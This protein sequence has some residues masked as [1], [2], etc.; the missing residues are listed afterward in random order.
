M[1]FLHAHRRRVPT[2]DVDRRIVIGVRFVATFDAGEA[3]LAFA[4]LGIYAAAHRTGLRRV[5]RID[6]YERP[7]A[8][9]ELVCEDCLKRS[10]S[11]V[12]NAPVQSALLANVAARFLRRAS[13]GGGHVFD[14]QVF[15]N[16]DSEAIGDAE[17]RLVLPVPANAGA[18]GREPRCAT[19]RGEPPLRA[20][21][22][23]R[24][25]ALCGT[26]ATLDGFEG[27]RDRQMLPGGERQRI[28]DAAI[29]PDRRADVCRRDM[30]NLA[31]KA[32]MP[33]ERVERYSDVLDRAA[34]GAC[35]S[36]F[37]PADLGQANGGPFGVETLRLDF[38]PL[39]AEGVVDALAARRRK[40]RPTGE[41]IG[42]RLVE[43][44]QR[45]LLARLRDGG[46]PIEFGA[47]SGQ[48]ARLRDVIE[49]APR[50]A[51]VMSPPVPALLKSQIVDQSAN[52]SELPEHDFL[53]GCRN[54][55][56]AK[57]AKDH[58]ANIA[59]G[60]TERNMPDNADIRKGRHV[61][62]ALHAHLVFVTKYRKDALSELAIRDLR[63]IFAKV[64]KDFE[65]ELIECNGEDDHVHLLIVYPPKVALSKLVN[66]LKG[67]SSR[68][69]REWR[70]EVRGRYKDGVLWSPSY[71]VASC[72]GAPLSIV[73]EYV[74]SQREA[75]SGR[76][77]LP[78]RPEGRSFSRGSR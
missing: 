72:G 35:V 54:Q 66:S 36:E 27:G 34:Q 41:E 70:P 33:S 4:A 14:A 56:V 75:P 25:D 48:F 73:A 18:F 51:L 21:L 44:A 61:V 43:I 53:F 62:Y 2:Q 55:L 10:P 68:L 45:L 11:L 19:D 26:T 9:F 30:P 46:N 32:D 65:A 31:G 78:P 71:F 17:R 29:N 47:Q 63:T 69:L 28:G 24:R 40:A 13:R 52:A 7:A 16:D 49:L 50:L 37:Y 12:E 59:V 22:P 3:R 58:S 76:S 39:K 64:C 20:L 57:A 8:L 67:V 42:E 77:R 60:P 15:E 74:K 6:L 38:A 1:P 5:G 23:A